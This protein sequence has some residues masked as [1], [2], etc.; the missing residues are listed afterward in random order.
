MGGEVGTTAPGLTGSRTGKNTVV[1]SAH[2][3]CEAFR[4]PNEK[5]TKQNT[6]CTSVQNAVTRT[7][8]NSLSICSKKWELLRTLQNKLMIS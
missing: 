8:L 2:R 5:Q 3:I 4:T 6:T 7:T 1:P